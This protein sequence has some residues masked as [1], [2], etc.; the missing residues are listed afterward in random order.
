MSHWRCLPGAGRAQE[1]KKEGEKMVRVL[2]AFEALPMQIFSANGTN[3]TSSS[4]NVF[5]ALLDQIDKSGAGKLPQQTIEE[6]FKDVADGKI[7]AG[8][9]MTLIETAIQNSP[10]GTV[11]VS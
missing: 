9:A 2:N 5:N 8:Q 4:A 7:S 3:G 10:S 6:I 11:S 1:P